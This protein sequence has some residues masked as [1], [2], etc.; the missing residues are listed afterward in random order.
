MDPLPKDYKLIVDNLM[1]A[2]KGLPANTMARIVN[3]YTPGMN[4]RGCPKRYIAEHLANDLDLKRTRV[5]GDPSTRYTWR[6]TIYQKLRDE[7]AEEKR[8]PTKKERELAKLREKVLCETERELEVEE[9]L[10]GG[11]EPSDID[12]Q[13]EYAGDM[14]SQHRAEMDKARARLKRL[15]R[16]QRTMAKMETVYPRSRG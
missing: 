6:E 16:I 11:H 10:R 7:L 15:K 12:A 4:W 3:R 1:A 14:V 5:M 13:I 9:W 2:A 8:P